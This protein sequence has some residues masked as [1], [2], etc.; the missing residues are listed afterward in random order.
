[1]EPKSINLTLTTTAGDSELIA[2]SKTIHVTSINFSVSGTAGT[3]TGNLVD[4]T[5]TSV[6]W[7]AAWP[8]AADNYSFRL[9]FSDGQLILPYH[10]TNP[11]KLQLGSTT[12]VDVHIDYTEMED[13]TNIIGVLFQS[14]AVTIG[15]LADILIAPAG[16]SWKVASVQLV[17]GATGGTV[18]INHVSTAT[19]KLIDTVTFAANQR[20]TI[21]GF[22]LEAGDKVTAESNQDIYAY[23]SYMVGVT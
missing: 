7:L 2:S 12:S 11:A 20:L 1:M 15:A 21:P 14:K 9:D 10:A 18:T 17:G 23:F 19:A 4:T 13:A 3:I 16:Q 6:P 5:P 22:T 8:F